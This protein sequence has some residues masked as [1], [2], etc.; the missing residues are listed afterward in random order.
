[1]GIVYESRLRESISEV[2][3]QSVVL[4]EIPLWVKLWP[5][6]ACIGVDFDLGLALVWVDVLLFILWGL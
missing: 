6:C 4:I 3:V 1:M 5:Q 2:S